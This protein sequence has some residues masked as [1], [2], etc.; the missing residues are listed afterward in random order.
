MYKLQV[1]VRQ[2]RWILDGRGDWVGFVKAKIS[3][4]RGLRISLF[5]GYPL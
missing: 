5:S 3:D 4:K 2:N 1:F